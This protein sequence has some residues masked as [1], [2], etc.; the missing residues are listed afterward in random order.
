VFAQFSALPFE[1]TAIV[2]AITLAFFLIAPA[3]VERVG[4]PGIVGIVLVGAALGPNGTGVLEHSEAIVLLGEAG[5]LYLLFLVGLDLDLARFLDAPEDPALFGLASFGVPFVVGTVICIVV[6]DLGAWAAALLAAVFASHTLL[7]YPVV[8]KLD[9]SSNDAVS[10]V[11]GGIVFTDTLALIVLA[12]ALG[13]IDGGV[14]VAM[15][16]Q[17]ALS[18]VVVFGGL[19]V[20]VPRLARWFFATTTQESYFEFLFVAAVLFAAAGLAE[21]LGLAGILGA[22]VAGLAI[23]REIPREGTLMNRIQFFGNAFFIPFFLFHVGMLIDPAVI[24]EGGETLWIAAV[25]LGAMFTTKAAAAGGVAAIRDYSRDE[26][27]VIFGLSVGQAAAALAITLLGLEAGVFTVEVLNAVVVMILVSAVV[28]PWVTERYGRRLT[29]DT[30]M[31]PEPD[32]DLSESYDPRI[33]FPLS[34]TT[35][36]KPLLQLGFV[37]KDTPASTPVNLLTV[38]P[39]AATDDRVADA[40]AHLESASRHGGAAEVPIET[41]T[42]RYH[43][44]ASGIVGASDDL[45]TDLVLMG[46]PDDRSL[47]EVL[48][49]D[50]SEQVRQQSA[51]PLVVAEL[52]RPI[53]ATTNV[54][55]VLPPEIGYHDGF[56]ECVYLVK[57]LAKNLEVPLRVLTVGDHPSPAEY[58][59]LVRNVGPDLNASVVGVDDWSDLKERLQDVDRSD[60]V[61]TMEAS[62]GGVGWSDELR[63]LSEELPE[64]PSEAFLVLTPAED[65]PEYGTR[66]L[67]LE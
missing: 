54:L 7:S 47:R 32:P 63:E 59:E 26:L 18:L 1:Q 51:K 27:G 14:S 43:N 49:D 17:I 42:R 25:I 57:R 10:A 60:L 29:A 4:L 61:V 65:V 52:D 45:S 12:I 6:L 58:E 50:V 34:P 23:N 3:I 5:L 62:Q 24:A 35:D 11:F 38:L 37:L 21:G 16:G 8:N 67:Q 48:F 31:G 46:W 33:L 30:T 36:S 15:L 41:D 64:F 40:E 44:P 19:L 53:D 22:F 39:P 9:L 28:S 55:L 2:L 56:D 20:V 66:F 13:G